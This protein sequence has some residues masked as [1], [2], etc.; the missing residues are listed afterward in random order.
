MLSLGLATVSPATNSIVST[1]AA[2]GAGLKMTLPYSTTYLA[3]TPIKATVN[4]GDDSPP[5]TYASTTANP[6]SLTHTFTRGGTFRPD[7]SLALANFAGATLKSQ[8]G[9]IYVADPKRECAWGCVA[10][11]Y[12]HLHLVVC[13]AV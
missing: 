3:S 2:G 1:C 9:T 6:L 7:V 10:W 12:L 13:A 8:P 5:D 4:W 11:Y